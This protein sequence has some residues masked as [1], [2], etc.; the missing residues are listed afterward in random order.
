MADAR[1]QLLG[2]LH[3]AAS[4]DYVR[5]RQAEELLKQWENEPSFFA[6]LQVKFKKGANTI[7]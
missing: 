1:S 3:G 2:V 5:M 6:T 4:Q 7:V